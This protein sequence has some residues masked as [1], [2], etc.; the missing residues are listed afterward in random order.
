M[1]AQVEV[2]AFDFFGTD[3]HGAVED[4]LDH[5]EHVGRGKDDACCADY[6]PENVVAGDAEHGSGED[7]EFS[8]EAAHH[9]EA[10]SCK[11]GDDEAGDHP[12]VTGGEAA[13]VAHIVG[14]VPLIQKAEEDEEGGSDEG[15]V[16]D[17]EGATVDTRN[18]EGEDAE[19]DEAD[20]R[21]GGE[22]G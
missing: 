12:R 21:E 16:E 11:R 5:G 15:F 2:P 7:E 13:V 1:L 17:L 4:A 14:A 18:G 6:R 22:A 10:D 3:A 19:G 9:G 20:V 8:N